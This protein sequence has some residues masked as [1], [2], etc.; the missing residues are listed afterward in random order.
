M[1]SHPSVAQSLEDT[2]NGIPLH[3]VREQLVWLG[4][5]P[6]REGLHHT[7]ARYLAMLRAMTTGNPE[8]DPGQALTVQ[9]TEDDYEEP[10]IVRD[11]PFWSLCEHHL[12]PFWGVVSLGYFPEGGRVVGLS[13]IPRLV[14]WCARRL[15]TQER[16]TR[17]IT[18]TFDGIVAPGG[19]GVIVSGVHSCM[20]MRGVESP[21]RLETRSYKGSDM[22]Q[23]AIAKALEIPIY[24]AGNV[25]RS[26]DLLTQNYGR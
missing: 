23:L 7:P 13:K 24:V 2:I 16:F 12:L 3:T 22:A 19:V 20:L 18:T 5:N 11:V 9:F 15:Q 21:G 17:D 4:E 10:V 25:I 1:A 6:N 14:R 26:F 8:D